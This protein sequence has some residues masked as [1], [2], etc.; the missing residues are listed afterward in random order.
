I[1]YSERLYAGFADELRAGTGPVA[2]GKALVEAKQDYLETTPEMTGL[3]RKSFIISTVF[4]LPM[5]SVDLPEGRGAVDDSTSIIGALSSFTADPGDSLG[6]EFADVEIVGSLIE[7]LVAL[8][9][10]D[11]SS[12]LEATYYEGP[13]G[14]VTNP[15][16]PVIPLISENVSVDGMVLRGVGFRGGAFNDLTGTEANPLLPLTGAPTTELRGVHTPFASERFFPLRLATVNN[17]GELS[18]QGRGTILNVTPA[19]HRVEAIGDLNA[20][21]RLYSDVDL[22]LYYS[23]NTTDYGGVI[24]ALAAPPSITNVAATTNG[25]DVDIE[26]FVVG[27]PAA[28][29]QEVWITYTHSGVSQWIPLDLTQDPS[30]S[31]RWF[32][33]VA[34]GNSLSD[35]EFIAQAVNGVGLV[36]IDD[37]FGDGFATSVPATATD[38]T[39]LTV[40]SAGTG[41]FGGSASV[42][43]TLTSFGTRVGDATVLFTLGGTARAA[44]TD[45]AGIATADLPLSSVP[46]NYNV[47]ASFA[48]DPNLDGSTGQGL[49]TIS[50][51]ATAL[52]A[53]PASVTILVGEPTG[54][55]ATLTVSGG[56]LLNE[57]TVFFT[58]A[59]G[60]DTQTVPVITTVSGVASLGSVDLPT[61]EYTVTAQFLGATPYPA[62]EDE[63][64]EASSDTVALVIEEEAAGPD[65]DGDGI[66]DDLDDDD[67]N[68]G[69]TDIVEIEIG[70]DPL[71]IEV[72]RQFKQ[73]VRSYL[74]GLEGSWL[75][76]LRLRRT[77]LWLGVSLHNSYWVDDD[78]LDSRRGLLVFTWDGIAARELQRIAQSDPSLASEVTTALE[79]LTFVDRQLTQTLLD[80]A[81]AAGGDSRY[82]DKAQAHLDAAD[83]YA[84]AGKWDKAI[85]E[86]GRGWEDA[87][88]A[89]G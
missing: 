49:F 10:L 83:A 38:P 51:A 71:V 46:G 57:R 66:P 88:R 3:H 62:G 80:E 18:E 87:G 13:D 2:V 47:T 60:V 29:I 35:L 15:A 45:G 73:A 21:L 8:T 56:G 16:Q 53:E 63:I 67:D 41:S 84:A 81:I 9:P 64:Y 37:S 52:T 79:V 70:T 30:D 24:P 27:D 54:I 31:T 78:T 59:N 61:G 65:T 12:T 25:S 22:R 48:G 58:V 32:G 6:L 14:V 5:I 34:G 75:T 36:A 23:S 26:M 86:Y 69:I 82:L 11:G 39:D 28:G 7:R 89:L 43:A 17:L 55:A 4:G 33:T 85:R 1:E 68:D 42:T 74:S 19:Q 40:A 76:N 20:I 77:G 50:K 72:G 44:T